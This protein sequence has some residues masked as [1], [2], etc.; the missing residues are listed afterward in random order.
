[1]LVKLGNSHQRR[2]LFSF[3]ILSSYYTSPII[4]M[5]FT[6]GIPCKLSRGWCQNCDLMPFSL[7]IPI[8]GYFVTAK[9]ESNKVSFE[10]INLRYIMLPPIRYSQ[11]RFHWQYG[12]SYIFPS[13][14]GMLI[15]FLLANKIVNRGD[16]DSLWV[17][18][19]KRQCIATLLLS[20]SEGYQQ[21]Y[22]W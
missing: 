10:Q 21:I 3:N 19:S 1:M 13:L 18:T 22:R 11:H 6:M 2:S 20:A 16:P 9:E 4:E 7:Q 17:S 15:R 12:K 14:L 5:L 8:L